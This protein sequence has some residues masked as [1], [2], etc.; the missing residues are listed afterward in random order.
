M[1]NRAEHTGGGGGGGG[2]GRFPVTFKC[3]DYPTL[4]TWHGTATNSRLTASMCQPCTVQY[5][6]AAAVLH[7]APVAEVEVA[8]AAV[9]VPSALA[10]HVSAE[11]L[12]LGLQ[13]LQVPAARQG[14]MLA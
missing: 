4:A 5:S 13:D 1:C 7:V 12:Q 11:G 6:D 3:C 9:A 10:V 2:G 14:S 8:A